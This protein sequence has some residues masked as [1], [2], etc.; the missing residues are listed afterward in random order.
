[1]AG[2]EVAKELDLAGID[3]VL[4]L[5][6]GPVGE[7]RHNN[8]TSTPQ[9]ALRTWLDP[10]S[11]LYFRRPWTTATSPHY[12]G[13]SGL[14]RRLGGRSLYWYG[15]CLPIEPWALRAPAWPTCVAAD[16]RVSWRSGEPLYG[17]V[18]DMLDRWRVAGRGSK[19]TTGPEAAGSLAGYSLRRTPM[20]VRRDA[21]DPGR[22]HAYSPLDSWR[23]PVTGELAEKP[24]GIRV[25]TGAQTLAVLVRHGRARGV[26]IRVEATG[27]TRD[28][29]ADLVVLAAGTVENTRLGIQSLVKVGAMTSRRLSGLAD[30]VVQGFFLRL[31]AEQAGRLGR[32]LAPGNSYAPCHEEARSNLFVEVAPEPCGGALLDVRVTGEQLPD[33]RTW[34]ECGLAAGYPWP[35]QVHALPSA[36][37]RRLIVT[38]REILQQVWGE[39]ARLTGRSGSLL[40]FGDFDN[41]LRTNAFVLPETIGSAEPGVPLPWSSYLGVED[42]EGCTLPIGTILSDDQEFVA[43]AG[44]FAAGPS[45][46]PRLGAAN[47]SM[48]NLALARRLAGRLAESEISG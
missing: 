22:W 46:F 28:I 17:R 23:D 3:G 35:V 43:V 27:Q 11:D 15:V 1:M 8:I 26:T 20:A 48:T 19:P 44:L 25:V 38:Q 37:D 18:T 47:P 24:P 4:V 42:H 13:P 9:A 30:H 7:V 36:A 5:E 6:A 12:S 32:A 45:V 33:E 29:A 2:L 40:D 21:R 41:P 10:R 39:V 31:S 16:L 14:R 34:V